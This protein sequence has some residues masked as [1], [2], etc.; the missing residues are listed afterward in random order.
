MKK[1][2]KYSAYGVG[3]LI[4]LL[5]IVLAIVATTFNPNDYKQQIIDLVQAKKSRTLK[6][7][8]DIKLSFWPKIGADL[9]KISLSEHNN[10]AEFASV[11]SVKV[12]LALLPLLKKELVVDTVYINGAHANIIKYKDGSTNFDDLI[13]PDDEESPDIKFDIDGIN[14]SNSAASYKDEATGAQYGIAKLNLKSGHVALAQPVD[15]VTDFTISANQPQIAASVKVKG[16]FLVDTKTK[17]YVVKGLD[18][19]INGD[20]LGGKAVDVVATGNMDAK[21]DSGE[22]L[23]DRLKLVASGQFSGAKM[24]LD[25]SAP[26]LIVQKNEVSSK[27]ATVSLT[28]EKAGDILKSNL[29]LADVK[30]SAKVLQSSGI[31]GDISATQ[32]KRTINGQFSS[33]FSGNLENL[34]FD[35]PKLAG[36]LDVKDP[37]LP[38]GGMQ[39][40]FNLSLHTD[41][42]NESVNSQ[43][44]L[45][46]DETKLNGEVSIT[47]FTAPNIKFN[48]NADKLNLNKLLAKNSAP[49][50]TNNKPA[51]LSTLKTLLLDGKLN[52]GSLM[53]DKYRISG[54]NVNIK[55]DGEKLVLS[56]LNVKVDDSQIKGSV[57]I[58]QFNKP[59]YTFNLDIDQLDVDKYVA[60]SSTSAD[61]NPTDKPVDLTVLKALNAD[62]SLRIGKLK[63]GK[64]KASNIRID[65][66]ADGQKLSLNPLSAKVDDS[67]ISANVGISRFNDPVYTFNINI[68]KL[69]ADKYITKSDQTTVKNTGDI[70]I[71]LSALKKLTASGEAK[72]GWLKLANVK[73][74][75]VNLGLKAENGIATLSPFSADLYQG[76]M[77]G[78]L[79]IDAR[80]TPSIAFKQ[81]MKS[82]AIGPLM[83]DAINNDMLDGKGT[84]NIDIST[85]GNSVGAL[86]KSL[87]GNAALSL[88]DGAL[89]GVDVAGSIRELKSKVN[90]LK[91]KDSSAA[92]SKK[93]T[94]FSELSASFIIKNGV[95]HNEDLAMKAPILRLV[96]GDS[97][98]DIDIANETINY[99]AKPSIVKSLKGQGGAELDALTGIAI[100]LKITGTFSNPKYGM[101][102][103]AISTA[104]A[105]SN[106]LD[107]VAGEKSSAVKELLG[108]GNKTDALKGLLEKKNPAE[109]VPEAN[110]ASAPATSTQTAETPKSA[111]DQVKEKATNKLK[112]LLNF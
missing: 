5:L 9:G 1:L 85:T 27:T 67:Q 64:T 35:L 51:D 52:V 94:D 93:K 90:F 72:I 54:L 56:G 65:L 68:D 15:L 61:K 14:V 39:G 98:G 101:D 40:S 91:A 53:Y 18:A 89:K 59:L 86:K 41:I 43:F 69:D 58:S 47:N 8:G 20:L 29:T 74:E 31:T 25:L 102:F 97:R 38:N 78:I 6:L 106:L 17:H 92:D 60:A 12:S 37:S 110:S 77:N 76:N 3:G 99:L 7:E 44:N 66:K 28:Q 83:V 55:A 82:I 88:V 26:S 33:S 70:P 108:S 45:N 63:Y 16:N 34:I 57:G 30:G 107:K 111:E 50:K 80:A 103:A 48:L 23:V 95:A 21:P 81:S 71:D 19:T 10:S 36:K 24:T 22:V 62:G 109:T 49:A 2:L 87:A 112:K 32:G 75:H 100:P 4:S 11:E 42:K 105:K 79:K 104:L 84:L 96:A 13:S 73:T 46:I